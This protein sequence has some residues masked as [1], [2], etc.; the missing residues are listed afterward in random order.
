MMISDKHT[1][2][3]LCG[4]GVDDAQELASVRARLILAEGERDAS[5]RENDTLRRHFQ[6]EVRPCHPAAHR[7]VSKAALSSATGWRP[8]EE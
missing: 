6:E 1:A 8:Q 3:R 5:I 2:D 4:C 7:C